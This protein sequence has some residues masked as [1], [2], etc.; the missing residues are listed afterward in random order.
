MN[1]KRLSLASISVIGLGLMPAAALADITDTTTFNGTV[2]GTCSYLSGTSQ[3]VAM[4]YSTD[5][6][7]T[8]TGTSEN[9]AISC[10]FET[11]VALSAVTQVDVATSTEDTATLLLGGSVIAT[12][13]EGASGSVDLGN[14]PG[15]TANVQIKLDATGASTVGN[16]Q[17]TVVLTT[18]SS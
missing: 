6:N 2:P 1:F 18:L 14:T 17:Y 13:G 11:D 3:D 8:L 12:S 4:T 15:S 16:Y 10:N 9:I 7:G 5:N